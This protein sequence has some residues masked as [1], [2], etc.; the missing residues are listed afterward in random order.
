MADSNRNRPHAVGFGLEDSEPLAL[1]PLLLPRHWSVNFREMYP[2]KYFTRVPNAQLTDKTAPVPGTVGS[3]RARDQMTVYHAGH[4]GLFSTLFF[5][6][7]LTVHLNNLSE[8]LSVCHCTCV[9]LFFLA[10][11]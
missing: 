4:R 9:Q 2:C 8:F 10:P 7:H 5:L 6:T 11:P 3:G 1:V